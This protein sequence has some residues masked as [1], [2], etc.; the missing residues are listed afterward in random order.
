VRPTDIPGVGGPPAQ[1]P[2]PDDATG[3]DVRNEGVRAALLAFGETPSSETMLD[4]LRHCLHGYL[5]LDVTG[6]EITMTDDGQIAPGST[7]SVR[8]GEGPDG[9][10]AMFAFT[11]HEQITRMYTEDGVE[12]QSLVQSAAGVLELCRSQESG[13][14]YLDPAGPTCALGAEDI[15]FALRVPRNDAVRAALEPGVPRAELLAALHA[16]GSLS[17][18]IIADDLEAGV[19]HDGAEVR[20]RTT[21]APDGSAEPVLAAFTSG[22]ELLARAPGDRVATQS[23]ADVLALARDGG[24]AGLL[25]NAAGPWVYLPADELRAYQP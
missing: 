6:S 16:E 19:V 20:V 9:R 1:D 17:L 18:A 2:P 25:L 11:S 13:W 21:E 15:D 10:P 4:V 22:P 24:F 23:S 3:S 8:G 14:L 12:T 5:L 7:I